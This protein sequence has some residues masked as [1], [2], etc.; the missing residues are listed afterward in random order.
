MGILNRAGSLDRYR[1]QRRRGQPRPWIGITGAVAGAMAAAA[2]CFLVAFALLPLQH[3]FPV[4]A[5]G[6][7]L[8]AASLGL[9]ACVAP[10]ETRASR[11]M[12][13]DFAG[14]LSL[15]GLAAALFGEPE[16][17]IALFERDR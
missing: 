5:A 15:I 6:L 4:T 13:W 17:A 2:G 16:Q 9:M 1:A 11:L 14:A 12:L 8:A 7:L 3:A 10:S